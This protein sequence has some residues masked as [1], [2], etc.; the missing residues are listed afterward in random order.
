MTMVR[1]KASNSA[2]LSCRSLPSSGWLSLLILQTI[3][4]NRQS[5]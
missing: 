1:C 3:H 2:L 5:E 4:L